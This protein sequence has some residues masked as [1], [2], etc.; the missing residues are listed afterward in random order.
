MYNIYIF[1][2]IKNRNHANEIKLPQGTHHLHVN[3]DSAISVA[4]NGDV[5]ANV[6]QSPHRLL[7]DGD[8]QRMEVHHRM[9]HTVCHSQLRAHAHI[10]H[11]ASHLALW[12]PHCDTAIFGY[13][14]TLPYAPQASSY[15][16][17][18]E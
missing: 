8:T 6:G 3:V 7:V 13:D 16:S 1:A 11:K 10:A 2:T 18:E 17:H 5:H 12:H 4:S 14:G 9:A 15:A